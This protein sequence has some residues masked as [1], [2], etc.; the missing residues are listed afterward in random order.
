MSSPAEELGKKVDTLREEIR[1]KYPQ[2]QFNQSFPF[3]SFSTFI[4]Q[5]DFKSDHNNDIILSALLYIDVPTDAE[6]EKACKNI[7]VK[8]KRRKKEKKK[9]TLSF[10]LLFQMSKRKS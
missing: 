10:S 3:F 6:C 5:V 2:G 4:F 7:S 9:K 8:R 1:K